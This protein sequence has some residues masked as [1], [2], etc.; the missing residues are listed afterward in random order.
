MANYLKL[1]TNK[2]KEYSKDMKINKN[3]NMQNTKQRPT[4]QKR[5]KVKKEDANRLNLCTKRS[6]YATITAP[7]ILLFKFIQNEKSKIISFLVV[8]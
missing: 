5:N 6:I 4:M 7:L 1:P 2:E 8:Y 3:K